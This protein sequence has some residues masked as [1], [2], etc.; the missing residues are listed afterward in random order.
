LECLS[1]HGSILGVVLRLLR[2]LR[3]DTIKQ[4]SEKR[5]VFFS[6]N[7][8]LYFWQSAQKKR[9]WSF[10]MSLV[11]QINKKRKEIKTDG[12]LATQRID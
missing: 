3:L 8:C 7:L 1:E 5:T 2:K 12:Y 6:K 4:N 10:Q 9:K 11:D